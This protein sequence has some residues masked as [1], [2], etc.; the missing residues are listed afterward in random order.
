MRTSST[1]VGSSLFFFGATGGVQDELFS[2]FYKIS[3]I[4]QLFCE[5]GV[6]S[7]SKNMVTAPVRGGVFLMFF[8]IS[9][10]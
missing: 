4:F 6:R 5:R 10:L 7:A 3:R 1:T 8:Q 9:C 2:S